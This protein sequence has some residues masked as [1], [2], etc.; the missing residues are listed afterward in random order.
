[1]SSNAIR[2]PLSVEHHA[3]TAEPMTYYAST[4]LFGW[5]VCGPNDSKMFFKG[6]RA[7]VVAELHALH[8]YHLK[9]GKEVVVE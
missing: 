7:D 9:F 2:I 3:F 5:R 8:R 6:S 4:G 1:M